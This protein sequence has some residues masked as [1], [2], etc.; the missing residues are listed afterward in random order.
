MIREYTFDEIKHRVGPLLIEHYREIAENTDVI[1]LDPDWEQYAAL[2][3]AG[4]LKIYAAEVA[5]EIVGYSVWFVKPHIHYRSTIYAMNDLLYLSP[6]Y[7][8][9]GL[10]L[11]LIAFSEAELAKLNVTKIMWHIKTRHD[12][13][14]ILLRRGYAVEE[15]ILAKVM[16]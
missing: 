9:T 8:N 1:P 2:Y 10:G 11:R 5:N 12:W 15:K 6:K 3:T 7:R 14:N 16:R 4:L 13:S